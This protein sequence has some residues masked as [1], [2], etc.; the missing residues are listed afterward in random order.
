MIIHNLSTNNLI[1]IIPTEHEFKC[2]T[3]LQI[4]SLL[5]A[6]NKKST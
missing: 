6:E 3:L 1:V 2:L 5:N 4:H